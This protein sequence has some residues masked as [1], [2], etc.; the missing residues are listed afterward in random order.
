M[1]LPWIWYNVETKKG[2][3]NMKSVIAIAAMIVCRAAFAWMHCDIPML[4]FS[5]PR[6]QE[7]QLMQKMV[8]QIRDRSDRLSDRFARM[9]DNAATRAICDRLGVSNEFMRVE[10][11]ARAARAQLVKL[12][13]DLRKLESA[14]DEVEIVR[15]REIDAQVIARMKSIMIPRLSLGPD[16][17]IIDALEFLRK[18]ASKETPGRGISFV[19]KGPVEDANSGE[20]NDSENDVGEA[21]VKEESISAHYRRMP[22]VSAADIS[23]YD[24]LTLICNAAGC[25]WEI[26]DVG[27]ILVTDDSNV[28]D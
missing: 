19:Y 18:E 8:E 17:T 12:I 14:L 28:S 27:F 7:T 21:C 20:E 22:Q 6:K 10:E 13:A 9:T 15:R 23:F 5:L 2:V 24:A 16:T 1:H 11:D 3:M 26:A 25:R 4:A